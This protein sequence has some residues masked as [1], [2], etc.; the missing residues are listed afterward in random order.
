MTYTAAGLAVHAVADAPILTFAA[1]DLY[2][3][4]LGAGGHS[5]GLHGKVFEAAVSLVER[6]RPTSPEAR[7]LCRRRTLRRVS[8]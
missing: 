1:I 6:R 3:T 4:P 7:Q 2:W 5:V 8:G